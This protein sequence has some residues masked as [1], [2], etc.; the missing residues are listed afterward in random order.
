MC[1]PIFSFSLNLCVESFSTDVL[2]AD[3]DKVQEFNKPDGCTIIDLRDGVI[4]GDDGNEID[5]G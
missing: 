3:Q 5:E 2:F 1:V 4:E